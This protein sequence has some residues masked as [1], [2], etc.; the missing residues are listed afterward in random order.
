MRRISTNEIV[1]NSNATQKLRTYPENANE[2]KMA[3]LKFRAE[4]KIFQFV[5]LNKRAKKYTTTNHSQLSRTQFWLKRLRFSYGRAWLAHARK[6]A[7]G[8][9]TECGGV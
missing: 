4:M 1:K 2:R 6:K 9:D 8:I 7:F 5:H 3:E